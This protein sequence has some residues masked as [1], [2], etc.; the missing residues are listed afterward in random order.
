MK[1]K[2]GKKIEDKNWATFYTIPLRFEINV[3]LQFFQH[4][5]ITCT[6]ITN[7]ENLN[8]AVCFQKVTVLSVQYMR[9]QWKMSDMAAQ[10]LVLCG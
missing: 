4:H 8:H 3:N 2:L 9:N 5:Y 7:E 1:F 6:L 10:W